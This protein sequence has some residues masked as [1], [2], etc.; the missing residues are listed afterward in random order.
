MAYQ[1]L[2]QIFPELCL[3]NVNLFQL[4]SKSLDAIMSKTLPH[5]PL[6]QLHLLCRAQEKNVLSFLNSG[7][8]QS[9]G[10]EADGF[11]RRNGPRLS[12]QGPQD[13]A[14]SFQ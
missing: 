3:E 6:D 8:G 1:R 4:S 12:Q 13:D 10:S 5:M 11:I 14:V 2:Q 9:H 7:H